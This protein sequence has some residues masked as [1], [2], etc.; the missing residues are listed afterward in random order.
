MTARIS[1]KYLVLA[2]A[3]LHLAF[4]S[5][6]ATVRTPKIFSDN[7]VLQA[8]EPAKIW[9]SADANS[10]IKVSAGN[11]HAETVADENG[12]WSIAMPPIKA[13]KTPFEIRIFENGKLAK[14]I[15]NVLAGEVWIAAGQ[16]N[17]WW[18]MKNSEGFDQA[19]KRLPNDMLR[20]FVQPSDAVAKEPQKDSPEQA[21][22]VEVSAEN[23]GDFGAVSYFFG[24][25][26]SDKL[27]MPVGIVETSRPG[28]SMV[29]WVS[30]QDARGVEK[31]EKQTAIFDKAMQNFDYAS[32]EKKY[33][34]D[35]TSFEERKARAKSE[36]KTFSESRPR[37]PH[38]MA[39]NTNIGS[40]PALLY[41]AK[42]A[43]LAGYTARGII[44]YQGEGDSRN[45]ENRSFAKKFERLITS[46][47][48]AWGKQDMPFLF[49]QLTS[50]STTAQWPQ[51]RWQQYEV[52]KKLGAPMAVITDIG[53]KN[54]VHPRNKRTVGSRLANLAFESVYKMKLA[55]PARAP[56]F[57]NVRYAG[58]SA[59]VEFECFGGSLKA[60]GDPRGFETLENGKWT[61]PKISL[62]GN[63]VLLKSKDGQTIDAVRC[64][65][66]NWA[67]PNLWLFGSNGLPAM[68]CIDTKNPEDLEAESEKE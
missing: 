23:I 43:P 68:G 38:K 32:A 5:T 21:K 1:R 24:E 67:E 55:Q 31:F 10:A 6:W 65:W 25:F 8:F 54:D 52:S 41:N 50:Y 26:L 28:S 64:F 9:G 63:R 51:T 39:G 11:A 56:V 59:E 60:K 19:K 42:I 4:A 13:A 61:T 3:A 15:R 62:K 35:L 48:N 47:R 66:E 57:K 7:M 14:T 53:A 37:A 2:I 49:V 46:W 36:G 34:S 44:W 40:A 22:W 29:A 20:I 30:R 12:Q 16:S 17:M 33:K 45:I 18:H 27:G 58:A